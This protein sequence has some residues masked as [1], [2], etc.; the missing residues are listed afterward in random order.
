MELFFMCLQDAI[1]ENRI[2]I[3]GMCFAAMF[4][5]SVA[6]NA[7]AAIKTSL[8]KASCCSLAYPGVHGEH[9]TVCKK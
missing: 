9:P 5:L 6:E 1:G 4:L 8:S 3:I 7:E 2:L